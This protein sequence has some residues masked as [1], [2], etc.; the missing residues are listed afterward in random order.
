MEM[1]SDERQNKC[2]V[3]GLLLFTLTS[4]GDSHNSSLQG[5]LLLDI[6]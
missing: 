1:Y 5:K 4:S 2:H 6:V 3:K